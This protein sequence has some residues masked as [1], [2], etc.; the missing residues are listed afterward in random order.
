MENAWVMI[1]TRP[2]ESWALP[3]GGG[4][5]GGGTGV[6]DCD[7]DLRCESS[8]SKQTAH[9]QPGG[10]GVVATDDVGALVVE[11]ALFP[12]YC[13]DGDVDFIAVDVLVADGVEA[14]SD[15]AASHIPDRRG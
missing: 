5:G 7:V 10:G 15:S 2:P 6:V 9:R 8:R 11:T 13:G 1:P 14:T 3:R 12:T 4:G